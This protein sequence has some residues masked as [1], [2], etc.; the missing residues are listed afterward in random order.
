MCYV[1]IYDTCTML[2][3]FFASNGTFLFF[4]SLSQMTYNFP[5][6]LSASLCQW[7][8][9]A[10]ADVPCSSCCYY[11]NPVCVCVWLHITI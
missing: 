2:T 5:S 9:H 6:P 4:F 1:Y 8:P 11:N 10:P 7:P 3:S